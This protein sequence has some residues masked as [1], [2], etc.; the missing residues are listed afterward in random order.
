M[1]AVVNRFGTTVPIAA[2][3][4]SLSAAYVLFLNIGA[5]SNYLTQMLPT[6][7]LA[8]IG[9]ALTFGPLNVAATNDVADHEQGLASGLVQT[10]FQLGGAIG[11]AVSTAVIEAGTSGSSA[12][13][14]SATALLD[15]FHPAL[16]VSLAIALLGIAVTVSPLVRRR[17]AAEPALAGRS[18]DS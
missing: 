18:G 8:G 16:Y 13:V 15:G 10:S 11:L 7:L 12:P 17:N 4:T 9:F 6:F 14:G 3:L 1:G 2:G 5:D